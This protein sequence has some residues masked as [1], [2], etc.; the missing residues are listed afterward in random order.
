MKFKLFGRLKQNAKKEPKIEANLKPAEE[1][2]VNEVR[3]MSS[4]GVSQGE[5]VNQL[6]NTGYTYSQINKAMNE[7]VKETTK[8]GGIQNQTPMQSQ[9]SSGMPQPEI[10]TQLP[11][12]ATPQ[13]QNNQSNERS[14][15]YPQNIQY[16]GP[17]KEE[18]GLQSQDAF[19]AAAS[20]QQQFLVPEN[21]E[22]LIEVMI[23][24]KMIDVEDEFERSHNKISDLEKIIL[25]LR[26][27]V[28]EL[29]IRKD[30]DEKKFLG[31]V[32]EIE[33]FLE[34]SQSR[35]G[36]LEKAVQQVLPTL[37]ENVRDLTGVVEDAKKKE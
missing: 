27:T 36:G 10:N 33:D 20:Q 18:L 8:M 12:K 11:P 9:M 29:Q 3:R 1:I 16:T 17:S 30:E 37:V 34:G 31:K 28:K 25:E 5:I 15:E 35:L 7:A 24:E 23:A 2:P 21:T 19:A 4:Q 22:E 13:V 6:R 26:D 32:I 14:F